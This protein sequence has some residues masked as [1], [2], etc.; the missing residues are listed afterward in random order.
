VKLA[1]GVILMVLGIIGIA[2][3]SVGY[4]TTPKAP[5]RVAGENSGKVP[6]APLASSVLFVGGLI[7]SA[8]TVK[9]RVEDLQFP[10]G[11]RAGML[12][13]GRAEPIKTSLTD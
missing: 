2:R 8:K 5:I 9:L 10:S 13:R 1:L 6:V 11:G 3:G 4:A 12:Q 7:I